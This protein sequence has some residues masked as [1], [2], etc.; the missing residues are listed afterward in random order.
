[1][2]NYRIVFSDLDGTLLCSH[3]EL[4]ERTR[5]AVRK[6]TATGVG[7]VPASSR[8]PSGIYP[9]CADLGFACPIIAYGGALALDANGARL[10]EAALPDLE[11][12]EILLSLNLSYP[13][14]CCCLYSDHHWF[15]QRPND[16]WIQLEREI[17]GLT[18]RALADSDR[19]S[20]WH[21]M[22]CMGEPALIA[23]VCR[24]I[25]TRFPDVSVFPS[26]D[27]FL[28]I[29]APSASKANALRAVC[30]AYGI[31]PQQSVAFGDH[32]ND[33]SMLEAAGLAVAMENATPDLK[34]LAS[35]IAPTNDQ[36]GVAVVLAELFDLSLD[37]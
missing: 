32:G 14:L 29:Q 15:A 28:E 22:M 36:D 11:V 7:F 6:L 19:I 31:D 35:R 21:K 3:H 33:A 16:P 24:E 12:R 13:E 18:P 20:Y 8:M 17:T 9:F 27:T 5:Q 23:R 1:M 26:K 2:K 37:D 4:T 10:Y 34:R 30:R 25:K